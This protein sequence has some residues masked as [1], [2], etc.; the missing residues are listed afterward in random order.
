MI[1]Q[2]IRLA[3]VTTIWK[4]YKT[5]ILSV[6][7]LLFFWFGLSFFHSEYISFAEATGE[8]QY[9]SL[10]FFVK[11]GLGVTALIAFVL[12]HLGLGTKKNPDQQST[13]NMDHSQKPKKPNKTFKKPSEN[14]VNKASE[15]PP[16]PKPGDTD[17]QAEKDPFSALRD[18][19]TLR[20]RADVELAKHKSR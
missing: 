2:F 11:W 9:L 5:N 20:S 8:R 18:K 12:F 19:P 16:A 1:K 4:R 15:P 3:I 17:Y 6:L 13:S 10:S 7:A 14:S